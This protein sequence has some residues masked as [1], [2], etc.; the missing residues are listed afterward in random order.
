VREVNVYFRVTSLLR[1]IPE[2][3]K[4]LYYSAVEIGVEYRIRAMV[5]SKTHRLKYTSPCNPYIRHIT[6][7]VHTCRDELLQLVPFRNIARL[8][9]DSIRAGFGDKLFCFEC[10]F[11]VADYN[12]SSKSVRN[13]HVGE[14]Y[15][16]T[17]S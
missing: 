10:E 17:S 16:Y 6:I 12:L 15:S 14:T 3:G 13:L 8:E 11:Y 2:V 4:I 5:N 1:I 7:F 9:N